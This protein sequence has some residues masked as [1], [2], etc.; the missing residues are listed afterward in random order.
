MPSNT[1]IRF[2]GAAQNVTGSSYLVDHRERPVR[3][4]SVTGGSAASWILYPGDEPVTMWQI[5]VMSKEILVHTG[6]TVPML[7]RSALYGDHFY[8]MM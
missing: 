1:S 2:L 7:T 6:T 4:R 3:E 5:D 8:S